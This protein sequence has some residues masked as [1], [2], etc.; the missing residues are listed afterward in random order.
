M[1]APKIKPMLE[2]GI[3]QLA[4][5]GASEAVDGFL[6]RSRSAKLLSVGR[7]SFYEEEKCLAV[8]SSGGDSQGKATLY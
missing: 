7:D 6:K 3:S 2:R 8:F 5:P 1:A 4:V